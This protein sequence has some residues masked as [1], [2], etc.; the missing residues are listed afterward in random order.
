MMIRR[1][2]GRRVVWV[3]GLACLI[4][5]TLAG[6]VIAQPSLKSR[7][8]FTVGQHPV[9]VRAL[10]FD[11]DGNLDL[12][13][14]NQFENS[15]SLMKGFGDGTFRRVTAVTVGSL[16]SGLVIADVNGDGRPDLVSSSL[17]SQDVTVNLGDGAGGFGGVLRSLVGGTPSSL[18]VGDWNKDGRLDVATVNAAQDGMSILLGD[19]SGLF[20]T[21]RQ[22]VTGISPRQVVAA[23]I[24]RDTNL[25]LVVVNNVSGTVQI[26]YGDGLG[27]FSLA[28]TLFTGSGPLSLAVADLNADARP[29]I[30]VCAYNADRVN[31]FLQGGSGSYGTPASL[32]TGFGPRAVVPADVD[33][34]GILDLVVTQSRIPL[35][36]SVAIL[37]GAGGGAFGAPQ[38]FNTGPTPNAGVTGDFNKDGRIDVVALS[39]TG[40]TMSVLQNMGSGAFLV[41]NKV[42]LP[43]GAFPHDVIAAD[44]NRDGK[45]DFASAFSGSNKLGFAF[46]DGAAGFGAVNSSTASGVTPWSMGT[47]D[48]NQDNLPDIVVANNGDATLSYLQNNGSSNFTATNG[49]AVGTPCEE[50]VALSVGELSGDALMDI[51]AVCETSDSLCTRRGTGSSGSSS[52][53]APVCTP[54]GDHPADVALGNYNLDAIQDPAVTSSTLN[55][56][57][58]G[59]SN[60]VG[61]LTDIPATFP[62]GLQPLGVARGDLNGDGYADLVIANTGAGTVSGLI[63]DG[64]GVFSFP[65]IDSIS[66]MAPTALALADF[67]L[68]G[69][70]DAAA[71]N[72]NSNTVALLLGDGTG[73]FTH[74]GHFGVRDQPI[75]IAAGDFNGDGKADLVVADEF[76][77]TITLLLNQ[78]VS[79]DPLAFAA[80]IGG[81]VHTVFRWGLVPGAVY[82]AIRGRRS[83][84]QELPTS[85]SLGAVVCLGNDLVENDTA[86]TPD[87]ELP[88]PGEA[89][90][91]VVRAV[92]GGVPGPYTL[93]TSG[94]PGNPS[95]GGCP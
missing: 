30:M 3:P 47:A 94:K 41:A 67:N 63:G 5:M 17:R 70:L 81:A 53:G 85:W 18:A 90:F 2:T 50:V 1:E 95:S 80:I 11:G 55:V 23:D 88:T 42:D 20:G 48:F 66:G 40:D 79:G 28:T 26:F 12:I 69:R 44:F 68:D 52:F 31:V 7:R 29:D 37:Y 36:G 34:N 27:I 84:A 25:D 8:D 4:G 33:G 89:F 38:V 13:T 61:G 9:A 76:N 19:G 72:T 59:F 14:A 6:P 49:L 45:V 83:Q 75:A 62:V 24:N 32:N 57:Q 64:G 71:V 78:S 54:I 82:D 22:L 58:I 10:D 74:A 51:A 46:G 60:G 21:L 65:S 86:A 56:V 92:I 39:L 43:S 91:Y 15:V 87:T 73:R 16:P 93:S 77:D 35:V